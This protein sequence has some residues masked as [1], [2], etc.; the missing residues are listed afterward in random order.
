MP[1][2]TLTEAVARLRAGG[3]VAFP[4]ETV[5]GL[6][7]D[8]GCAEAV[9]QVFALKGRPSDHPLI[10]HIA[11]ASGL[12]HWAL[13]VPEGAQ[14]L[15]AR[16]WPG[17]LTLILPR[18]PCVLDAVT[19]GQDTVGLRCPAH[20]LAQAL[21][22]ACEAAGIHGLA[23][24]SANRFGRLSPTAAEHV[25]QEFGTALPVLDGGTCEVGIESTIVDFSAGAPRLL[26]PGML[27]VSALEAALGSPLSDDARNVPRVSGSLASHYAPR[28]RLELVEVAELPSRLRALLKDDRRVAVLSHGDPGRGAGVDT[29]G[30]TWLPMPREAADYARVLYAQLRAADA[31]GVSCLLVEAVPADPAWTAVADRLRRAAA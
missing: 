5:Y 9:A 13:R 1:L 24:P 28:T 25:L 29:T 6:G 4:T 15:A 19:G 17:P 20:P 2:V 14:R 7:A 11:A 31:L 16:F 3:T 30:V 8:A 21:L 26:R 18:A 22:A 23:A 10:V 27:G 12:G